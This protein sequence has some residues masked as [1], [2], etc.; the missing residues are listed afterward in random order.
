MRG[1]GRTTA[2]LAVALVVLVGCAS[3]GSVADPDTTAPSA[4]AIGPRPASPATVT[5]LE[6]KNGATVSADAATLRVSLTGATL[7]DVT[8]Q[9]IAPDEGHLHVSVDGELISMTAGL[10]QA[11]PGLDG[12]RHTMRVE[13]VAADHLPFDPRVV[14]QGFF[15]V[16]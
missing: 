16:R 14:T 10:T 11:M 8:S 7:T 15:E 5:I 12:G 4:S 2:T 3:D 9:T 6:P 1:I 13:F